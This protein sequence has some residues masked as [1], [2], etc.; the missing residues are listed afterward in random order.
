ME[1]AVAYYEAT[2]KD[3]LLRVMEKNAEHIYNVFIEKGHK[4]YPGH[5]EVELALMKMYSLTK[6]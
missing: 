3:K 4:S 1:A 5:P 6:K 2:G